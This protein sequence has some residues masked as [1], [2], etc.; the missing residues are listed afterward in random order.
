MTTQVLTPDPGQVSLPFTDVELTQAINQLPTPFGQLT[1]EGYFPSESLPSQYFSI[2]VNQDVISALPVTGDGPATVAKHGTEDE[3]I[4]RVPHMEHQDD[5][6]A[7]DIR[8]WL[9]QAARTGNPETLANLTNRRL[10]TLR[11]KFTLTWELMRTSA[12]KGVVVDGK[13]TALIDLFAA[14][15]ISKKEVYFDL[16]ND[17]ADP[18]VA[19]DQVYMLIS[20]DLSDETM[21]GVECRCS[22]LFFN[23]LIKHPLVQKYWLQAEQALQ[24]ANLVR[25]TDGGY[26]PRMLTLGNITFKEYPAVI[27]MWGG[28]SQPIIAA[29]KAHA[30]PTGTQDTHVT[31]VAPPKDI[32]VLDGQSAD[33]TDAIHITTEAMKHGRGV[34][35]LGQA[36]LLP[37]WRRPKLL[38][39][40][41]A[42]SG[43]STVA[44]DGA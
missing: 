6:L 9:A 8:G 44:A 24:L 18:A 3:R 20:Q 38:V 43:S 22:R 41:D 2:S 37:F 5:I 33:V 21:T 28:S 30:Y 4:F 16:D 12:I 36:N 26:R 11:R 25:G 23:K 34:E 32:R 29:G 13:G 19:A 42:G 14:F 35:V 31:Y 7:D 15:E 27:P 40:L 1:Q 39:E 10:M 17:A